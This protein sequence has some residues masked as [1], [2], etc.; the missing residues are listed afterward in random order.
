MAYFS[1]VSHRKNP[2]VGPASGL[3]AVLVLAGLAAAYSPLAALGGAAGAA[4][5]LL[6][7]LRAEYFIF[8]IA[9]YTPL[10]EFVL[11]WLP[12]QMYAPARYASEALLVALFF[13]VLLKN[14][15]T[16]RGL[17]KRTPLDLPLLALLLV[18][19]LSSV[20]NE[21]PAFI[22][23]LGMKNL[24]RYALLFYIVVNSGMDERLAKRLVY[25]LMALA[26]FESLLGMAQYIGGTPAYE[27]FKAADVEVGGAE[28]R[29]VTSETGG[30]FATL[31]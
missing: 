31:G 4:V 24:L 30:I 29:E 26:V 5:F 15:V 17:W 6:F 13:T 2:G 11:K 16:R 3:L 10:E 19:T 14:F 1:A 27:F 18:I 20:V 7:A 28:I 9:L 22:A 8:F 25:A 12:Q 21:V 23:A